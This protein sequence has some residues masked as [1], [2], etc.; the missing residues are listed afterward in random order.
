MIAAGSVV[1]RDVE[2]FALM[3]G[4]PA[5]KVGHM[6]YC[7]ERFALLCEPSVCP[8]CGTDLEAQFASTANVEPE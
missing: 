6:C 1:T 8:E 3:I 2:P 5:R 7:G 4:A